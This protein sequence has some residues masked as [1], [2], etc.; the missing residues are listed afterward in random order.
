MKSKLIQLCFLLL[1]LF[2]LLLF[3]FFF[4][5]FSSLNFLVC[6]W[7]L[8]FLLSPQLKTFDSAIFT[9][10]N[11]YHLI[12]LVILSFSLPFF[13]PILIEGDPLS[14]H[15]HSLDHK[16]SS[17][18]N[19]TKQSQG[20]EKD[21]CPINCFHFSKLFLLYFILF[22]CFFLF[23]AWFLI[24]FNFFVNYLYWLLYL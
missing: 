22:Q 19:P 8:N 21:S 7:F 9:S 3:Q 14:K 5:S 6:L 17:K 18:S 4:L 15:F 23:R 12:H 24:G 16:F 13:F 20:E 2:S 11:S 10:N 1:L